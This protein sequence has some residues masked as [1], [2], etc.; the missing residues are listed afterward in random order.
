MVCLC[1]F[2]VIGLEIFKYNFFLQISF[3]TKSN[4]LAA[5][6]DSG[7]VKVLKLLQETL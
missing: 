1:S 6:D 5:A 4:F 7:E 2:A 3:S